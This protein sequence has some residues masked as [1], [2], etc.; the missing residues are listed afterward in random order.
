M[1][2]YTPLSLARAGQ[3]LHPLGIGPVR[4][5][6]VISAGLANSNYRIDSDRGRYVLTLFEHYSGAAVAPLLAFSSYL[7]QRGLPCPRPLRHADGCQ[8][9]LLD[10]RPA[11]LTP[12]L[13]GNSPT[14]AQPHQARQIGHALARLH[15]LGANYRAP[16]AR[17]W[18]TDWHAH[19]A[20]QLRAQLAPPERLLLQRELAQAARLPQ[21][22]LPSGPI[23]S[24]LFRDNTLFQN[25]RLSGLLDLYDACRGPLIHDLAVS[26]NDWCSRAD[27]SLDHANANAL[28]AGYQR[29]RPLTTLERR[30]WPAMLR[31]AA[32][33][34]WILRLQYRQ[35]TRW[36]NSGYGK[37][38]D[39]YRAIL[40]QRILAA[41][42]GERIGL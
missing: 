39:E 7:G 36:H 35:S 11:A 5:I 41:R 22:R 19:R 8:W 21:R 32:V 23:H 34:F 12:W 14:Q 27:G 29:L 24:D 15:R 4:R 40:R 38:P 18:G 2:A 25:G 33:R 20:H 37:D 26:V 30:Q 10:G 9:Q 42:R 13:P 1:A 17:G 31:F 16:L 28:L 6:S 3:F